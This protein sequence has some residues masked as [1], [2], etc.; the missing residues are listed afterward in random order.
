MRSNVSVSYYSLSPISAV[1]RPLLLSALPLP[2]GLPAT[3][4]TRASIERR[5]FKLHRTPTLRTPSYAMPRR[6]PRSTRREVAAPMP[7][8]SHS[9]QRHRRVHR[10]R[11]CVHTDTVPHRQLPVRRPVGRFEIAGRMRVALPASPTGHPH[12]LSR[13][14]AGRYNTDC[15]TVSDRH[16]RTC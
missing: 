12:S 13:A 1:P 15:N 4:R 2:L 5:R 8:H 10:H 14:H 7:S 16:R 11:R 9:K 3:A 6:E